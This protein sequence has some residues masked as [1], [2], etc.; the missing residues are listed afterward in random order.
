[1]GH[2]IGWIRNEI[3]TNRAKI[4]FK[5]LKKTKY[6]NEWTRIIVYL[7]ENSERYKIKEIDTN[8]CKLSL[9]NIKLK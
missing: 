6:W 1:M 2:E 3:G 7:I 8:S 4:E 5:S 9:F